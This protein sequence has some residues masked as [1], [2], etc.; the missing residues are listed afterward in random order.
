M[1]REAAPADLY[2]IQRIAEAAFAPFVETVGIKPAPML[3]DF[4]GQI[5]KGLI[6]VFVKSTGI[7]GY[8]VSYPKGMRW[9]IESI[10]VAPDC[11]GAGV[12]NALMADTERRAAVMGFDTI[13]LYTNVMMTDAV[14]W[15]ERLGYAETHRAE[16][17]GFNR[18]FFAKELSA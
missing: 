15:Y 3:A 8:C 1:I 4:A 5:D 6:E 13:E 7:Q 10:A 12:G 14:L 9:H 17:D 16:Q 18:V 2:P 11:Q